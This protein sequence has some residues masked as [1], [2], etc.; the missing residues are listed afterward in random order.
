MISFSD[1]CLGT[2]TLS[3]N[4]ARRCQFL[5]PRRSRSRD[6]D[7]LFIASKGKS[8]DL[9]YLRRLIFKELLD[10]LGDS[11]Y[12]KAHLAGGKQDGQLWFGFIRLPEGQFWR[13]LDVSL[14]EHNARGAMA[15]YRTGSEVRNRALERIAASKDLYLSKSG[16]FR[17]VL[18]H[19]VGRTK[20]PIVEPE[21][22][23]RM[24]ELLEVENLDV[25]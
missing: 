17:A 12:I 22:E 11:G 14:V 2:K 4:R 20:D 5:S 21:S 10:D 6:I 7:M 25:A 13:R 9:E 3:A 23:G 15:R 16:L 19:D 1:T 24:H 18:E 8:N